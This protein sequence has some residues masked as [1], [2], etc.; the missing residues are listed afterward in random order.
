M[1][2][3]LEITTKQGF[4]I[5]R[6]ISKLGMKEALI[7]GIMAMDLYTQKEQQ[8]Y[9]KLREFISSKYDNYKEMSDE[10]KTD[11]SNEMLLDHSEIQEEL[12]K[13]NA[14]KNK[15]GAGLMYDFLE[16]MPQAE[17]E[18]YKAIASIYNLKVKDVEE[19]GLDKTV[20]RIKEIATSKT[21]KN[22]FNLAMKLK[23]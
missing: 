20:E 11:A 19:D 10:E 9:R 23:K 3:N 16:R 17:K 4:D 18:I 2:N 7:D 21:F 13:C 6:I 15:V 5:M 1:E 12:T 22:F 8:E 14:E